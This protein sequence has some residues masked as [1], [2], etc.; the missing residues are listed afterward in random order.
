MVLRKL[1]LPLLAFV[2]LH[3][4]SGFSQLQ[5]NG[6]I[7]FE[8]SSAGDDSRFITNGVPN[9][10]RKLNLAVT[11]LNA[12]LF[13]PISDEFFFES[14]IQLDTWG[15]GNL[16]LPR[17]ALATLTWDNPA[18]DYIIKLG[19]F[20]SPFGFYPK[21]QLS[22]ERIF[23]NTPLGYSY[24][25]NISDIRGYW[26]QA[27]Q[28]T[29][30]EYQVGDVGLSTIY[31]GGYT[32]GVGTTWE[33]S[34]DKVFLDFAITN[35]TPITIRDRSTLPNIAGIARLQINPSIYWN[36]G[37]SVS[38]GNFLQ[39]DPL[40][41]SV[42]EDNNFQK[43]TQ[44]LLGIDTKLAFT[45]FEIV[46]EAIYSNWNVPGFIGNSFDTDNNNSLRNYSLSNLSGNIDIKYEPPSF[47]GGFVALRAEH[48]LFFDAEDPQTNSTFTWD[49]NVSRL[50]GVVGYKLSRNILA[51]AAFSEQGNFDG[52]EY[53]FRLL[54][55]AFF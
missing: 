13:A 4:I 27:G 15:S 41:E 44:L 17:I 6:S 32:T 1:F 3:P 53:T 5:L 47:T 10:F 28:N 38:Y 29:N 19:R 24:F 46:G 11:Q 37:F 48:L 51:K 20:V 45:F 36:Q 26:P 35:G 52:N 25:T 18:N 49:E 33:V 8:I 50:T 34:A 43:Y 2:C 9:D 42:R 31:F 21:R 12:F 7:D 55:S 14:R 22:T 39:A 30:E 16:N 54:I 23:I 40:N